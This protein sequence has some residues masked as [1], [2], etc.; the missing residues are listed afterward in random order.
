MSQPI[1][2]TRV[3]GDAAFLQER[4]A[5]TREGDLVR[6]LSAIRYRLTGKSPEEVCDLLCISSETLRAWVHRWN[7]SG[8]DGLRTKPRSGRPR[9]LTDEIRDLV[10]KKIE[11]TLDDGTPFTAIAFHGYLKKTDSRSDTPPSAEG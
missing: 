11:G 10:V 6:R 5:H 4:I 1:L 2:P 8:I 7:E 9:K 3:H